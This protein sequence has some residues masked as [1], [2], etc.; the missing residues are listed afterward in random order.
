MDD[1]FGASVAL[2]GETLAVGAPGE[3]SCATGINGNQQNPAGCGHSGAV[4]VFKRTNG[5]WAQQAYVKASNTQA[6]DLFGSKVAL[7]GNML[8][9]AAFNEASCATGINGDQTNNACSGAGAVY[10]F[11][12]INGIW[13]QQAYVKPS[14]TEVTDVV[15]DNFG[16]GLALDGD[17]LAVGAPFE[18]S[19]ATGINGDQTNNACGQSGA[20][21]VFTRSNGVWSQQAYVKASNTDALDN[22][23]VSVALKGETLVVGAENES[24][25]A[26]GINGDQ[27]NNSCTGAGAVY[28]YVGQ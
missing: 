19:C 4:Y 3:S 2:D 13:S 12:Q 27:I 1:L 23:G 10:V 6:S 21:Y 5:I 28:V 26:R 7:S 25:C 20:V 16:R 8:A 22:F 9:A 17:T 11:T 15:K 14:N 18:N 24:S